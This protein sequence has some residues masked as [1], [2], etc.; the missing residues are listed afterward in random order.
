MRGL[1]RMG[2]VGTMSLVGWVFVAAALVAVAGL[3]MAL[4][5][6]SDS[7]EPR[8]PIGDAKDNPDY[9]QVTPVVVESVGDAKDNPDYGPVD[10]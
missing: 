2:I 3:T 10:R 1:L 9:G 5:G 4:V 8:A 6:G 7:S